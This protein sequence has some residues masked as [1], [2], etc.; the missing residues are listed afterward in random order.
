MNTDNQRG[1]TSRPVTDGGV[2]PGTTPP[3]E[4][5]H[6]KPTKVDEETQQGTAVPL[7]HFHTLRARLRSLRFRLTAERAD[8]ERPQLRTLEICILPLI[9]GSDSHM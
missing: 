7:F 5:T 3:T 6:I 1:T 8:D 4:L 9:H 2:V